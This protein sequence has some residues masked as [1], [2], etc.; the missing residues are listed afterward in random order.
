MPTQPVPR[1]IAPFP[2]SYTDA[3]GG[4][5]GAE[6]GSLPDVAQAQVVGGRSLLQSC[7]RASPRNLTLNWPTKALDGFPGLCLGSYTHACALCGRTGR[8]L[9]L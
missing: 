3:A 2:S 1:L 6:F 4:Q 7:T 5:E 9:V 8:P